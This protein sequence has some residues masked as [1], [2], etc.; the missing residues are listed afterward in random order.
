MKQ[1]GVNDFQLLLQGPDTLMKPGGGLGIDSSSRVGLG[2]TIDMTMQNG[3]NDGLLQQ[4]Q[5]GPGGF[6]G[7][8][9]PGMGIVV[10]NEHDIK[11]L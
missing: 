5:V 3:A 4:L 8:G 10:A 9:I 2:G 11:E 7:K 6:A 1:H